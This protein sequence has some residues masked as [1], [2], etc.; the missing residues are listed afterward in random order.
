MKKRGL[1]GRNGMGRRRRDEWG[2]LR[3]DVKKPEGK[4]REGIGMRRI[5]YRRV[6]VNR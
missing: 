6:K 5:T 1:K 3:D 2:T 4:E